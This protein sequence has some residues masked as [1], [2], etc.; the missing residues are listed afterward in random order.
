MGLWQKLF[1][2]RKLGSLK[3][4]DEELRFAEVLRNLGTTES[5]IERMIKSRR[6]DANINSKLAAQ[7]ASTA[8]IHGAEV[9][10]VFACEMCGQRMQKIGIGKGSVTL[11][12]DEMKSGGGVAEECRECGRAYCAECYPKRGK[13]CVCGINQY[14]VRIVGDLV[15]KG[16]LLLIKVRYL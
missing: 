16:S 11:S 1:V 9:G 2:S 7:N 14:N 10:R 6:I 5:N 3:L 12:I 4:S 15:H 13:E 8:P